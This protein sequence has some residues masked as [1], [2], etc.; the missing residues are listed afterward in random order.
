M[1]LTTTH[2]VEEL[3]ADLV[4]RDLSAL[5]ALVTERGMEISV[6]R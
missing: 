4:A 3:D 1:A 5:S 2:R 6:R